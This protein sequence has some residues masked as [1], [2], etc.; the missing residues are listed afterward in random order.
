VSNKG[1]RVTRF[2]ALAQDHFPALVSCFPALRT[3]LHCFPHLTLVAPFS[4]LGNG[5]VRRRVLSRARK[6]LALGTGRLIWL[7]VLIV[8]MCN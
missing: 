6:F 4:R 3:G 7:G 1:E 5:R 2:P 8:Q